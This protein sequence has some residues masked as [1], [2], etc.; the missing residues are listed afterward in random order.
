MSNIL[1]IDTSN[2]TTSAALLDTET[3]AAIQ[4]KKLLPVKSGEKGI[5]QS[6]AVF[7]HTKQMPQ[8]LGCVLKNK[9]VISSIG[10]SVKPRMTDGSYMPCF[11]VGETTAEAMGMALGITPDKTSHQIGHILSAL[12]SCGKLELVKGSAPFIAF[13]VSGGTTDM[14]LCTPDKDKLLDIKDIG[15]SLDLKA[16][17]VIDRAGVM[18]GLDFPCGKELEKLAANCSREFKIKPVTKGTDCCLSGIE[19]QCHKLF[20][21]G[22]SKEDIVMFCIL[23]VCEAVKSMT[24]VALEKYGR[25]PLIYAGGVMSDKIIADRIKEEFG[26]YFASPEFSCDNAVGV[27]VYSALRK[28]L[29]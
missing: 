7:H 24:K 25:M 10:V 13:H 28:G 19:N 15:H 23:S 22:E 11:L 4:C 18:L 27:A 16:G 12:F 1:G 14:L 21:L 17:Q 3:M 20:D 5:R 29:I 8:V 2:Y 6:D 9:T 26:G